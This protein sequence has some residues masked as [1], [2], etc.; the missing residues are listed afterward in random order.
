[1]ADKKIFTLQDAVDITGPASFTTMLKPA[2]SA[3]NLDCSYCYYL[4]K[5][6]QYGGKEA[7]MNEK[8]L[9]EYVRQ[10]LE[11]NEMETVSFCWHGGEPTLLGIDYYRKALE[12]QKKYAGGRKI[13]NSIQTNGTMIDERWCDFFLENNFL[14]GLSLDGPQDVHDAFRKTKSQGPTFK[15]VMKTARMFRSRGVQFNTLSVVNRLSEKRGREIYRFFRDDVGSRYMQFLPA[16]EHVTD[17]PGFHRP[18]IV[19]PETPGARPAPWSVSAE[20]YG[21]FLCDI[22]DTWILSDVG[23]VFIQIFDSTLALYAGANPGVCYLGETCGNGL[24][25]E[26]NG[27]VYPCDHFVYPEYLLGNIKDKTLKEI[28][29]SDRRVSFGLSKRNAL[30]DEC[31]AC[32]YFPLCHGECPKHRF[33]PAAD[34]CRKNTLCAG[35]KM[36]FEHT[37]PYMVYMKERLENRQSPAWV[38]N[39]ARAKASSSF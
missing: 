17:R 31:L 39:Y 36:F 16:V 32:K 13:E 12:F 15:R 6:L 35:L 20:G 37:E 3:C 10:Y 1:M 28:Y 38:M 24:S 33:E 25:V 30:P 14:V 34:G 19:S 21:R 26:H 23:T 8:L 27:D 5:A 9:E 11:A 18:V 2:G 22:F 4:D 7:V 29:A